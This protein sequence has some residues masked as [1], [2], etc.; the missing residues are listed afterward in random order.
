MKRWLLIFTMMLIWPEQANVQPESLP[1]SWYI[2]A[3]KR[4]LLEFE[5]ITGSPCRYVALY[6][7]IDVIRAD[8]GKA[9]EIEILGNRALV[10][11][12]ASESTLQLLENEYVRLPLSD[13]DD[14]LSSLTDKEIAGL[15]DELMAM[16]YDTQEI[17]ETVG[18]D[19][20]LITLKDYLEMTVKRR[21]KPRY[22]PEKDEII[23]D[24]DVR[25]CAKTIRDIKVA[26]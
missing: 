13:L 14:S 11:V 18:A 23:C 1:T 19:L 5:Q 26:L 2:S 24:G 17:E 20:R 4:K 25:P 6:D 16:G 8:G 12:K 3:Y 10:K 21:R 7:Y 9:Q 22:D 15:R